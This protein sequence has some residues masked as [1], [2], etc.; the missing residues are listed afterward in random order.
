MHTPRIIVK[1]GSQSITT[2]EGH[3]YLTA[4]EAV[5]RQIAAL[6]RT[7]TQV[8]LVTSG[9][10]ASGR[11]IYTIGSTGDR[12][13]DRIIA[14]QV[15]AAV[16]MPHL[17]HAYTLALMPYDILPAQILVT[18]EDF[19]T[20]Q[21]SLNIRNAIESMLR[22]GILPIV[23]ENDTVSIR[24]LMFTDNDELAGV[25]AGQLSVDR[26]ILLTS[27]AGLLDGDPSDPAARIISDVHDLSS[28]DTSMIS[29]SKTAVGRGGMQSKVSTC[30]RAAHLG[31]RSH[32]ARA[33]EADII[34][35]IMRDEP[36]GT[37]FWPDQTTSARKKWIAQS[38]GH[39]QG[40]VWINECA[41]ALFS[42]PSDTLARSLL[43]IGVT[44]VEGSFGRGDFV[45]IVGP[46][47][48]TI[49]IGLAEY[50]DVTAQVFIGTKNK[51]PLIRYEHMYL[52]PFKK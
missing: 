25:L 35:R 45:R 50:D 15:L 8:I 21:H 42:D 5:I 44:R 46:A 33:G 6:M 2:K 14:N 34:M 27:V 17:M 49:G 9:A 48:D 24:E 37:T 40:T 51:P 29:T 32:I 13:E 23:N 3:L 10:V 30:V 7:G 47:G 31:I 16:G 11:G 52:E 28:M 39:E 41:V 12:P 36:V 18:K 19:R 4:I 22:M 38:Q 20:R 26:L 43:P 1:I